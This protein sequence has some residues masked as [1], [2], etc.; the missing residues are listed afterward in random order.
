[1]KNC[2]NI[3]H[4]DFK[5]LVN[6]SGLS[7][8][9]L[10]ARMSIWMRNNNTSEWPSLSDIGVVNENKTQI[11]PGVSELFESNPELANIGTPEQYSQYL[12]TIFPNSKVKEIV[13]HGSTEKREF[14]DPTKQVRGRFGQGVSFAATPQL[15]EQLIDN[16]VIHAAIINLINPLTE[17]P[18]FKDDVD[19]AIK[20]GNHDGVQVGNLEYTVPTTEQIH[21][22]GSKED[23]EG[24][25]EYLSDN[26]EKL[27]KS[28]NLF[29][30][31]PVRL[32][33][34]LNK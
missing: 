26:P 25:N 7:P 11:K 34:V 17:V 16:A 30:T 13:Y 24:F 5:A 4:K 18:Q 10:S 9:A 33:Y 28:V 12:D 19:I 3:K 21:I 1:M 31:E 6:E 15:V 23:I 20:D 29:Y 22:L 14:L 32:R 2:I 8:M 27:K